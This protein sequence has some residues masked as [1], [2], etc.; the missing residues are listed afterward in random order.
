MENVNNFTPDK[1][2][3][4]LN[5]NNGFYMKVLNAY[6]ES[7]LY[8]V[9]EE[10]AFFKISLSNWSIGFNQYNF[11]KIKDDRKFIYDC[12]KFKKWFGMSEE[13][14]KIINDFIE[15]LENDEN[16]TM[17]KYEGILNQKAEILKSI[18]LNY[19]NDV[20]TIK[21]EYLVSHCDCMNDNQEFDDMYI[22][23]D[24]YTVIYTDIP[25]RTEELR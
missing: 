18:M 6:E 20:T 3:K 11:L 10:L 8:W 21:D 1:F 16:E 24:D 25:A 2:Q 19:F 12:E 15:W 13:N 9:E 7:V 14:E 22:K 17:E 5:N 23:N 4:L